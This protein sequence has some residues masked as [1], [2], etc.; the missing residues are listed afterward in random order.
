MSHFGNLMKGDGEYFFV[1][2]LPRVWLDMI[3]SQR[4]MLEHQRR[5]FLANKDY[6]L[7]NYLQNSGMFST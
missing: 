4:T 6:L 5:L 3:S 7:V 1:H 2:L